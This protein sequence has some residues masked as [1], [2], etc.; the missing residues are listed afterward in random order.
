MMSAFGRSS[1]FAG[2]GVGLLVL[3]GALAS[4]S[5]DDAPG[6]KAQQQD[7]TPGHKAQQVVDQWLTALKH[8]DVSSSFWKDP[9]LEKTFFSVRQW[10]ILSVMPLTVS[11]M[12]NVRIRLYSSNKGGSPIITDWSVW[13]EK[14]G[15]AWKITLLD[16][17]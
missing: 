10:E 4:C 17:V 11:D 16:R 2:A 6:H 12:V 1:L 5:Q 9:A 3:V 13:L 15:D 7:N 14:V 8:G